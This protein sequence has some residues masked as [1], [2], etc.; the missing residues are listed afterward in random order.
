MSYLEQE[1]ERLEQL[2][3]F[4]EANNHREPLRL[5]ISYTHRR[6]NDSKGYAMIKSDGR[7]SIAINKLNNKILQAIDEILEELKQ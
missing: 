7:S 6:F 5:S 3:K 4:M 1:I 2:K